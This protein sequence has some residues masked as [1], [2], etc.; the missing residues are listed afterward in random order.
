MVKRSP[1]S[2]AGAV[3][4]RPGSGNA[5]KVMCKRKRQRVQRSGDGEREASMT[6]PMPV[7]PLPA[8]FVVLDWSWRRLMGGEAGVLSGAIG[9]SWPQRLAAIVPP[10]LLA[11][12]WRRGLA[13]GI[14][15]WSCV[16]HPYRPLRFLHLFRCRTMK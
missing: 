6:R 13:F 11:P 12:L 9:S 4:S 5:L 1:G 2:G 15:M 8:P 7:K 3:G 10:R 16:K 14:A